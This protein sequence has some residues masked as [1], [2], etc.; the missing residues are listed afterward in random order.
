MRTIVCW[1]QA[2]GGHVLANSTL[3]S[4]AKCAQPVWVS[5]SGREIAVAPGDVSQFVC[6]ECWERSDEDF[7]EP[8]AV[9]AEQVREI[10]KHFADMN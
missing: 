10:Q 6:L 3:V 1:P 7:G 5:P 9:S 2:R 4:C 8:R